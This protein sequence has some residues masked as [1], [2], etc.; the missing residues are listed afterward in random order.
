MD[1]NS[2]DLTSAD[3]L[4]F[5][6]GHPRTLSESEHRFADEVCLPGPS[7]LD[8]VASTPSHLWFCAI[9]WATSQKTGA[10][11]LR[12]QRILGLWSGNVRPPRKN[13]TSKGT[14]HQRFAPMLAPPRSPPPRPPLPPCSAPPRRV[15]SLSSRACPRLLAGGCATRRRPRSRRVAGTGEI[16]SV[17]GLWRAD[18][19]PNPHGPR[20]TTLARRNEPTTTRKMFRFSSRP[21]CDTRGWRRVPG[22]R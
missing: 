13:G 9:S 5:G 15:A 17:S 10:S 16:L 7:A 1:P 8:A 20:R 4:C 11:A 2:T 21:V 18:R 22:D 6:G 14:G 19:T 3:T 12:L